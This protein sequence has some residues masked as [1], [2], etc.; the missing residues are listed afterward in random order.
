MK[1]RSTAILVIAALVGLIPVAGHAQ[2]ASYSQDFEAL[3]HTDPS[4]LS[5]DGWVVYGNVY[6]PDT[7]WFYGYGTEPAPNHSA[8]FC[9]ID[10]G[11]GGAAQGHQQL[12]VFSDYENGDHASGYLIES[13]VF[14]EQIIG[15]GDVNDIWSFEFQHK[16]GNIG[17]STSAKAFIKTIDPSN[18][19]NM[20]NFFSVDM[21]FSDTLWDGASIQMGIDP[22]LPGQIMQIGFLSLATNYEGSGIFYDNLLFH[23]IGYVGVQD[24]APALNATLSQNYPNPFN[25]MTQIEFA[26]EQPGIVDLSIFDIAGRLVATLHEGGLEAGGHQV[27]WNGMTDRGVPASSGQY[28]YVLETPNGRQSRSMV[29][30]K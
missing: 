30:V 11:Q 14:R 29:L 28:L 1:T 4:A 25:P 20:T 22:G 7:T 6:T 26:L 23:K 8:A 10:T 2:L 16:R 27:I 3:G 21:T 15:A 19:Y 24:G 9:Q 13:N 5:G 17:G 18:N 12:V